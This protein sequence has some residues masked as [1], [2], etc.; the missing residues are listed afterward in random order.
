MMGVAGFSVLLSVSS[1]GFRIHIVCSQNF[2]LDGGSVIVFLAHSPLAAL[3]LR[4][5][6]KSCSTSVFTPYKMLYSCFPFSN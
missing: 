6:V 2:S 1:E 4:T 5:V 3:S